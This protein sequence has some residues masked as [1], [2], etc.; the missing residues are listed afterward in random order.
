M[1]SEALGTRKTFKYLYDFGDIWWHKIKV[2]QIVKLDSPIEYAQCA[3][4]ENACHARRCGW[5]IGLREVP[6]GAGRSSAS[7]ARRNERMDRSPLRSSRLRYRRGQCPT[8]CSVPPVWA[9][10][11]F[12]DALLSPLSAADVSPEFRTFQKWSWAAFGFLI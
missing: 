9:S 5:V 3:G 1:L 12:P 6:Q 4:G 7:R 2:E 11:G 8:R 10:P